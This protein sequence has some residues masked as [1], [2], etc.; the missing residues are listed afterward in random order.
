VTTSADPIPI[1]TGTDFYVPHFEVTVGNRRQSG[2]VVRDVIQV[3]YKDNIEQ[4][5]SFELTVNNWDA[6]TRKF[7]YHDRQLFDPG[8]PVELTMGYLNAAGGGLRTMIR[9]EITELRPTFPA[10]GQPTL[11]VTGLNILHRFRSEQKSDRYENMTYTEIARRVCDRLKVPFVT[12]KPGAPEARFDSIGQENEFDVMFLMRLARLAGYDLVVT[13]AGGRAA[14]AF[15]QPLL[16][17]QPTYKL[18]YG[19][20][21]I[22]FQPTLSFAHQ[23]EQVVVR[24]W[25]PIKGAAIDVTLGGVLD[26]KIKPGSQNPARGRK[27]VVGNQPVQNAQAARDL[28][29]ATLT[30]IQNEAV[31]ATGSVVGL[32]DLRAGSTIQVSGLGLRF[33]GRYFVTAT[34]HTLGTS[35]YVTQFECRLEELSGRTDGETLTN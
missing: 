25:D 20:G 9:G 6:Q 14:I 16:A 35:G 7:K 2:A 15:G 26:K 21:L 8:Q 1:Y 13:E 28:A 19:R 33:N 24:G 30:R 12:L 10:G 32:P 27:E 3:T 4:I 34:T 11:S 5:D 29:R 22:E 18:G 17:T 23:V 31:K